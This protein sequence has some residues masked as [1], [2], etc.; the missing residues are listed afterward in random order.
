M[1]WIQGSVAAG[2]LIINTAFDI[3]NRRISI[4][5]VILMGIAG[6]GW[7][8]ASSQLV[9]MDL[10]VSL[11]PGVIALMIAMVARQS[12][13][14]GDVWMLL[15]MGL[16]LGSEEM[17]CSVLFAMILTGVYAIILICV[18][19]KGR[20]YEI[21]FVPFLMAGFFLTLAV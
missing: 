5:S 17:I 16:V 3:K 6:L 11:L 20:K 4:P 8:L 9:W 15:G 1:D 12:I 21:A 13:G 14:F 19:H 10:V 7:R 18:F 2:G